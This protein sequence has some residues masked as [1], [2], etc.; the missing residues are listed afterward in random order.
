MVAPWV[1]AVAA[2][3][4]AL[5]LVAWIH[6]VQK[7]LSSDLHVGA[8]AH[9]SSLQNNKNIYFEESLIFSLIFLVWLD[10]K[11]KHET[12]GQYKAATN[13]ISEDPRWGSHS[14]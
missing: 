13:E 14:I 3:T 2:W 6:K 5:L 1:R 8:V 11:P 12:A 4:E 9:I 7:K 10:V